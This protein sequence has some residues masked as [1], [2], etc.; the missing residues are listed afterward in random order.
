MQLQ[1]NKKYLDE[2][3]LLRWKFIYNFPKKPKY[4]MWSQH[5]DSDPATRASFNKDGAIFASIEAKNK[6]TNEL[7]EIV[8]C[9]IADY[10]EHRWIAA[11]PA[12][13]LN[14]QGAMKLTGSI[15]GMTLVTRDWKYHVHCDGSVYKEPMREARITR[16]ET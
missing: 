4:G 2:K 9:P 13:T 7:K 14:L 11:T 5:L 6:I 8:G 3:W 1:I 15:H 12:P 10:L 16:Y